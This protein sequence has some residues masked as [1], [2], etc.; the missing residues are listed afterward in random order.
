[1]YIY[2]G[3]EGLDKHMCKFP[4]CAIYLSVTEHTE[5]SVS[6]CDLSWSFVFKSSWFYIVS[7]LLAYECNWMWNATEIC[8]GK[9]SLE[10]ACYYLRKRRHHTEQIERRC[11]GSCHWF[12]RLYPVLDQMLNFHFTP[13][14]HINLEANCLS[15]RGRRRPNHVMTAKM[16]R[17]ELFIFILLLMGCPFQGRPVIIVSALKPC[18][19]GGKTRGSGT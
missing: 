10:P 11:L 18:T 8:A 14:H 9:G 2:I 7:P 19:G 12:S 1:M 3:V 6:N 16:A 4:S 13:F 15:V 17:Q 5:E